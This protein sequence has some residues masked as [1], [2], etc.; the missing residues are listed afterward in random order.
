M[1]Y[2]PK[3]TQAG[4]YAHNTETGWMERCGSYQSALDRCTELNTP[5]KGKLGPDNFVSSMENRMQ[6]YEEPF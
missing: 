1:K 3:F 4:W 2:V 5:K 6:V